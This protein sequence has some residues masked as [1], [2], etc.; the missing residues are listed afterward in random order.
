MPLFENCKTRTIKC[1]S[2]SYNE[3]R[4]IESAKGKEIKYNGEIMS[5]GKGIVKEVKEISNSKKTKEVFSQTGEID[6]N[7][8]M[9][10]K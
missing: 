5:S 3:D 1:K 10:F 8:F 9:A 7:K 2:G 4:F 6:E